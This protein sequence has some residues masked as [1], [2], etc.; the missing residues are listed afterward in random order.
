MARSSRSVVTALVSRP[1]SLVDDRYGSGHLDLRPEQAL[2]A[3]SRP[4]R[5]LT[6]DRRSGRDVRLP[7]SERCRQDDR[8]QA[9]ARS[10][11]ADRG[12]WARPRSRP[13][14]PRGAAAHRVS[15]RSCFAISH[16][17]VL[18]RSS[19]LHADLIGLPPADRAVRRSTRR[20]S[21]SVWQTGRTRRSAATPRGCSSVSGS[22]SHSSVSPSSSSSTSRRRRSIRS[23]GSTCGRFIRTVR[24]RGA[25]GLPQ[26]HLL[27]EVELICDRVAI[28]D[29]GLVVAEGDLPSSSASAEM[30]VRVTELP[31]DPRRPG[32]LRPGGGRW[33][34]WSSRS[35]RST[36]PCSRR[37]R[38]PRRR[39]R[40]RPRR[41]VGRVSLEDALPDARTA[42]ARSADDRH[43]PADDP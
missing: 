11:A 19:N 14:R 28:V 9:A 5:V 36:S 3:E 43:R 15:S 24:G 6:M 22:A 33:P 23:A 35:A 38:R 2:R 18:A 27:T 21:S 39:R 37:R 30:R 4:W 34:E 13:R 1:P 31:E 12:A 17:C 20:S 8:R 7:G 32:A 41:R 16:G 25:A 40:T 42:M 29:R 10:R 26:L